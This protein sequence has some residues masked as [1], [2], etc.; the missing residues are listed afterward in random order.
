M[1]LRPALLLALLAARAG[2][3]PL[4][5]TD[6]LVLGLYAEPNAQSQRLATLHS[7]APVES[8]ATSGEFTQVRLA[9]GTTGWVKTS[10]LTPHEPASVRI[11]Q[12]QDE[13][14]RSRAT[15]PALAEAA[16]RNEVEQL[17]RDLQ[18]VK[19]DL[20]ATRAELDATR[21][22]GAGPRAA[23]GRT[24]RP[25]WMVAAAMAVALALGVLIGHAA[26]ARR[27]KAKFGG[28]KV[29]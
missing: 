13:L 12:L 11:K 15:T 9:T 17:R 5:V 4:Y 25:A 3:E 28:I 22:R 24:T 2:A 26:L 29:Y 18:A 6:E 7:A 23:G 1:N 10:F 21:S 27:I 8:L 16:A 19:D 14:D 20:Q